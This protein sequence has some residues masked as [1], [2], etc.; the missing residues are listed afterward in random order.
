MKSNNKI[1]KLY[2]EVS[3][4]P[5]DFYLKPILV[6]TGSAIGTSLAPFF[7]L[8]NHPITYVFGGVT[9]LIFSYGLKKALRYKEVKKEHEEQLRLFELF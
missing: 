7:E 8:S 5:T 9:I 1:Y 2:K 4:N 3:F 6:G